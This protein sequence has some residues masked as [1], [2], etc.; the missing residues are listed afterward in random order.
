MSRKN[1]FIFS[2]KI[3]LFQ[4]FSY[5]ISSSKHMIYIIFVVVFS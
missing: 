2:D 3:D 5:N 1:V 4:I